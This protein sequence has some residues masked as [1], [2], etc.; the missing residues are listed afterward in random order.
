VSNN[1]YQLRSLAGFGTR[2]RL[3]LGVLGVVAVEIA[4]AAQASLLVGLQTA[5]RPER[6]QGWLEWS[7]PQFRIDSGAPVEI[8]LDGEALK[9]DP[10]LVFE[11][12]PG[13]L[14]IRIPRA[15]VGRSPAATAVDMLSQS[16]IVQ[17]GRVAAGTAPE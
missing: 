6:F 4:N 11:I 9:L 10:P 15:A 8:G 7:T 1:P 16:T 14:R 17:L 2:E 12:V 5:G 13:A 3:D